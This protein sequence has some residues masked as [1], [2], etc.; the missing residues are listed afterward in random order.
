MSN[1]NKGSLQKPLTDDS[2]S[3]N[4]KK[5]LE[6]II[7]YYAQ[8][9]FNASKSRSLFFLDI[10]VY[11]VI[12][13][14]GDWLYYQ[15]V[16]DYADG[17]TS[18]LILGWI[19][20]FVTGYI[21]I[22]HSYERFL[23]ITNSGTPPKELSPYMKKE[24]PLTRRAKITTDLTVSAISGTPFAA[25]AFSNSGN[26]N[27][28]LVLLKT[29]GVEGANVSIHAEPSYILMRKIYHIINVLLYSKRSHYRQ[30]QERKEQVLALKQHM[31]HKIN[32]GAKTMMT[33]QINNI[34]DLITI[35]RSA[36]SLP[37]G[38]SIIIGITWALGAMLGILSAM[39]F[40]KGTFALTRIILPTVLVYPL[41][42]LCCTILAILLGNA[43]GTTFGHLAES[44]I[45]I[46]KGQ[47]YAPLAFKL[48]PKVSSM[49]TVLCAFLCWFSSYTAEQAV[50]D[51]YSGI[52]EKTFQVFAA[53]GMRLFYMCFIMDWVD[54]KIQQ[55]ASHYGDETQKK[56]VVFFKHVEAT[57]NAIEHLSDESLIEALKNLGVDQQQYL[58][59]K[60]PIPTS[61]ANTH[62]V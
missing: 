34:D 33:V 30:E 21:L 28:G 14:L 50:K 53:I 16:K 1:S 48:Y 54:Q 18:T 32:R 49:G 24:T 11:G 52:T 26:L 41:T 40:Y 37:N 39:G 43:N 47:F 8:Q 57:T 45:D 17:D 44:A 31:I 22:I 10:F 12:A 51:N 62:H 19:S 27:T 59:D 7:A 2:D 5:S 6:S 29:L 15:P 36:R 4:P 56:S 13:S 35:A 23:M 61:I 9:N 25:N 55:F 38:S 46:Y 58:I 20:A 3:V 60:L 42:I